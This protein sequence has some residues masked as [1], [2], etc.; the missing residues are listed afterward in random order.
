M[1]IQ[2][3][4]LKTE[5]VQNVWFGEFITVTHYIIF[6]ICYHSRI[7]GGLNEQEVRILERE[8]HRALQFE[9]RCDGKLLIKSLRF[10]L[11]YYFE[12]RM[13][14]WFSISVCLFFWIFCVGEISRR[15]RTRAFV[16]I[17]SCSTSQRYFPWRFVSLYIYFGRKFRSIWEQKNKSWR[18]EKV[19]DEF[20]IFFYW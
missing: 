14:N 13:W 5:K 6:E 3:D 4:A 19:I 16:R 11:R 15:C 10:K 18:R 2:N 7:F 20:W 9:V 17:P 8:N 12:S 1:W